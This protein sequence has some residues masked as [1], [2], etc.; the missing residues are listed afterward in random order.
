MGTRDESRGVSIGKWV[1][2]ATPSLRHGRMIRAWSGEGVF[3]KTGLTY[4]QY[5]VMLLPWGE[6]PRLVKEPGQA[7]ELDPAPSHPC[8]SSAS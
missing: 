3:E 7:L 4:P 1:L 5:P 8:P 6:E 2:S